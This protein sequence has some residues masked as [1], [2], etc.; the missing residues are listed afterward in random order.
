MNLKK[1]EFDKTQIE[2]L[3]HVVGQYLNLKWKQLSVIQYLKKEM[4][5]FLGMVGYYW[6]FC[7]YLFSDIVDPLTDLFSMKANYVWSNKCQEAFG[8][9]EAILMNSPDLV[10][11]DCDKCF[12]VTVDDSDIGAGER[13]CIRH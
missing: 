8:K 4:M 6:R 11:P 9:V 10:A 1:C 2:F 5:R 12:K 3:G 13:G 7:P